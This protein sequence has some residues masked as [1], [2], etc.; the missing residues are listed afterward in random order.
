MYRYNDPNDRSSS[1]RAGDP[2][3][4]SRRQTG[5]H[6]YDYQENVR[7]HP[8]ADYRDYRRPSRSYEDSYSYAA[9]D[10]QNTSHHRQYNPFYGDEFRRNRSRS[11][12]GRRPEIIRSYGA[13][14]EGHN[15]HG[16]S[17]YRSVN[18]AES[19]EARLGSNSYNT[20]SRLPGNN[21]APRV[22]FD[23]Q[24]S[25]E[26]ARESSRVR[27]R[28]RQALRANDPARERQN[29]PQV[30]S[31]SRG[32]LATKPEQQIVQVRSEAPRMATPMATAPGVSAQLQINIQNTTPTGNT[33]PAPTEAQL[34]TNIQHPTPNP[35]TEIVTSQ[36]Q[37]QNK[38]PTSS[39][40][41]QSIEPTIHE[42]G[43]SSHARTLLRELLQIRR[44]LVKNKFKQEYQEYVD[45]ATK[46]LLREMHTSCDGLGD[47][48]ERMKAKIAEFWKDAS[49]MAETLVNKLEAEDTAEFRKDISTMFEI[50][51]NKP[52]AELT[53]GQDLAKIAQEITAGAA[54]CKS[55]Q[56][57]Q[58]PAQEGPPYNFERF[59]QDPETLRREDAEKMARKPRAAKLAVLIANS[60]ET[61]R[62]E[63]Q[64]Y[65]DSCRNMLD[66][67]S[68]QADNG[69]QDLRV[70][71][72][73][74]IKPYDNNDSR[75]NNENYLEIRDQMILFMDRLGSKISE[76]ISKANDHLRNYL[77]EYLPL[78]EE[79]LTV[80]E[81]TSSYQ[82]FQEQMN[83]AT[84]DGTFERFG[85]ITHEF[86]WKYY[87]FLQFSHDAE[88]RQIQELFLEHW[89]PLHLDLVKMLWSDMEIAIEQQNMPSLEELGR[90]VMHN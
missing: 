17:S 55:V 2:G 35:G 4:Q 19:Y 82:I 53:R 26:Q 90:C 79:K 9:R 68:S 63:A 38:E 83:S 1:R 52:E 18:N 70:K 89:K 59:Q 81:L 44:Q 57:E 64:K 34:Q 32:T 14:L 22:L 6:P 7:D 27:R 28:R 15:S 13:Q 69:M 75:L 23:I 47:S 78:V 88:T 20:I 51:F 31:P 77:D 33:A 42:N 71:F 72:K 8:S 85:S 24:R 46:N 84:F 43:L 67:L 56:Q 45:E 73:A 60:S 16:T 86:K 21:P 29:D 80:K 30:N 48:D 40:L 11:P 50:L 12:P 41:S 76:A 87:P 54:Q 49:T 37:V 10:G 36:M 5:E 25:E 65:H 74:T 62:Q 3:H 66:Y 61:C 58:E 39:V